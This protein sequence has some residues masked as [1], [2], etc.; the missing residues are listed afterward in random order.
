MDLIQ[1]TVLITLQMDLQ[2][3]VHQVDLE[4]GYILFTLRLIAALQ[5]YQV[6]RKEVGYGR[7]ERRWL[8]M[9]WWM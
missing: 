9:A 7:C 2:Y 8:D 1:N 6:P 4:L 3:L 5:F